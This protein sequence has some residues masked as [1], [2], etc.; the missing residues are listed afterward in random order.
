M[1]IDRNYIIFFFLFN[2]LNIRMIL[3]LLLLFLFEQMDHIL[4]GLKSSKWHLYLIIMYARRL[5]YLSQN[6]YKNIYLLVSRHAFVQINFE[7]FNAFQKNRH[8]KQSIESSVRR[9]AKKQHKQRSL[10]LKWRIRFSIFFLW[11]VRRLIFL[12]N[13][14]NLTLLQ[15]KRPKIS[16]FFLFRF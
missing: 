10:T 12:S 15:I 6:L 2:M 14:D 7:P 4:G 9:C 3:L 13:W 1:Y 5:K 8:L 16:L 11:N